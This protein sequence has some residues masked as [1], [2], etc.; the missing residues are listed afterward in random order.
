[1]SLLNEIIDI[2]ITEIKGNSTTDDFNSLLILLDEVPTASYG[3]ETIVKQYTDSKGI[4][5]DFAAGTE[6]RV[7]ADKIFSQPYVPNKILLATTRAEEAETFTSLYNLVTSI[8]DDF[9]FIISSADE[10]STI[11]EVSLLAETNKK[12]YGVT[13]SQVTILDV[14]STTDILSQLKNL[15]RTRTFLFYSNPIAEQRDYYIEAA[16]ISYMSQYKVGAAT[17][18]YKEL[19]NVKPL[20]LPESLRIVLQNKHGNY[21]SVFAGK[22]NTF[23]G[24]TT[25]GNYID[26]IFAEDWLRQTIQDN[27]ATLLTDQSA[28]KIPYTQAGIDIVGNNLRATMQQA[29]T[30]GVL[31][32]NF[33]VILPDYLNVSLADKTARRLN[34]VRLEGTLAGAIHKISI[35]CVISF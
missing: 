13:S 4:Y 5:E 3:A 33:K 28:G 20:T 30:N 31:N 23:F 24:T 9:K 16:L 22:G 27:L 11:L 18:S 19:V 35:D 14:A 6:A 34:N 8:R 1:M 10:D 25:S 7:I 17:W 29:V 32:S 15:N 21:F 12:I 2:R 26:V